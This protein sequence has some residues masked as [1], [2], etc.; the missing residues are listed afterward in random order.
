MS[1]RS[2]Q[3]AKF[4]F[5]TVLL[6]MTVAGCSKL[7][8]GPDAYALATALDRVF[9]KQDP[10]QLARATELIDEYLQDNRLTPAEAKRLGA[11]VAQAQADDWSGARAQLRR[12]LFDQTQW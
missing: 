10:V 11:L 1:T 4:V 8:L 7:A 12:L 9:E 3:A 6:L 5:V 2:P